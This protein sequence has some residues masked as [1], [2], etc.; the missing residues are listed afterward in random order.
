MGESEDAE[1]APRDAYSEGIMKHKTSPELTKAL[2]T[3]MKIPPPDF[4]TRRM[5]LTFTRVDLRTW[6]EYHNEEGKG[7]QGGFVLEWEAEGVGFGEFTLAKLDDGTIRV[8]RE[9]MGN[10]FILAAFRHLLENAT[11]ATGRPVTEQERQELLDTIKSG[12]TEMK[13]DVGQVIDP[14]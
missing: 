3:L 4:G 12:N 6:A 14:R 11:D 7:N 13:G 5:P 10:N 1:E 9:A 8:D 2:D